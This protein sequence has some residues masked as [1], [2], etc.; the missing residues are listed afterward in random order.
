MDV[1]SACT[2]VVSLRFSQQQTNYSRRCAQ[3]RWCWWLLTA[4]T[5]VS[6]LV[7]TFGWYR[8]LVYGSVQIQ[9]HT[10]W[11]TV[12]LRHEDGCLLGRYALYCSGRLPTFRRFP[13]RRH[14]HGDG[15]SHLGTH[16]CENV[17]SHNVM[18]D[19]L[20]AYCLVSQRL[21]SATFILLATDC[22]TRLCIPVRFTYLPKCKAVSLER[23]RY[24]LWLQRQMTVGRVLKWQNF[25]SFLVS[26]VG[27]VPFSLSDAE[28][29]ALV[30]ITL[31]ASKLASPI[32][33]LAV[34]MVVKFVWRN[35]QLAVQWGHDLKM[36]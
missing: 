6:C 32:A 17:K 5:D 21:G 27:W 10:S 20:F 11:M 12:N 25:F 24:V 7:R 35:L 31:R 34:Q 2:K 9:L 23:P 29:C 4:H 14:H 16:R 18:R 26:A 22:K 8:F 28:D 33:C 3:S 13:H 36:L 15:R 19:I 1:V 30:F